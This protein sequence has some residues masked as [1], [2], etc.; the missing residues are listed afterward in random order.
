M[1]YPISD[2]GG[3]DDD[4]A[5]TLKS[6]G[7]RSTER[8]LERASTVKQ[9]KLLAEET[10]IDAKKLLSW[11]NVADRMRIKGVSREYA[12]LLGAVGVD[13]VKELKYRNAA[14]LAKAMA[15]ANKKRKLVRLVPSE[16]VVARW[17]E[18]AKGLP[19]KIK[20]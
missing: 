2:I 4:K 13:T 19:L 11:A 18:S 9:R 10:G 7:I 17:I 16:R 1:S 5:A 3:I 6:A 8:L 20:Y 12:E 15:D 14:N